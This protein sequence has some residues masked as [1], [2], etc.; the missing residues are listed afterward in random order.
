[1]VCL[2]AGMAGSGTLR[3]RAPEQGAKVRGNNLAKRQKS[4]SDEDLTNTSDVV[5]QKSM[6]DD[7]L[8][9]SNSHHAYLQN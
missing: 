4:G 6:K 9:Y 7:E 2:I 3:L 1:M 5:R 8:F